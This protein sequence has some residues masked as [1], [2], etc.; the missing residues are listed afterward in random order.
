VALAGQAADEAGLPADAEFRAALAAFLEWD[1]RAD[2]SAAPQWGVT[3]AGPPD[4]TPDGTAAASQPDQPPPLPGLDETVSFAAHVRP[5]FRE[6]DHKSM[7]FAF[8]LW[9]YDDVRAHAAGILAR[10]QDGSMPCDGGWPAE[11]VA[12]FKRWL[13]SGLQP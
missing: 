2:G 10:L 9:S 1:S 3:A 12:V 13:D 6:R 8:D 5:L 7:S 4:T 11:Q